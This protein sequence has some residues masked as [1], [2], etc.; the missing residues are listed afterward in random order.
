[1]ENRYG[2]I[3][4]MIKCQYKILYNYIASIGLFKSNYEVRER[5]KKK[6]YFISLAVSIKLLIKFPFFFY[7]NTTFNIK[8]FPIKS[9]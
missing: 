3:C 9:S 4:Y 6:E 1:M 8:C 7:L 5:K 2:E